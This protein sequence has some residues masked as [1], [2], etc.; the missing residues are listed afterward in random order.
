MGKKEV[1]QLNIV[2]LIVSIFIAEMAA[3]AVENHNESIFL[4]IIPIFILV[5][6]EVGLSY[7]SLKKPKFRDFLDGKPSV[8]IN[9]GQVR[10]EQMSKLRYNLEDLISQLREQGIRSIEEVKYAILENNGKLSVFQKGAAYPFPIIVDGKI[11]MYVLN[12][13]KKDVKWLEDILEEKQLKL[14]DIF[15]A[16]YANNKTFI[17]KNSDLI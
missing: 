7:I 2:D 5:I 14:E 16:F 3:I 10:F 11:D 13:I 1:G 8:I 6:L 15:Y 17:I 4:S 9:N 12:E